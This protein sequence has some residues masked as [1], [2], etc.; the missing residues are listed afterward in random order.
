MPR[1]RMS[2]LLHSISSGT[3]VRI[4]PITRLCWHNNSVCHASYALY[5][6]SCE[7][8]HAH[9]RRATTLPHKAAALAE[10]RL[11]T[12]RRSASFSPQWRSSGF[13]RNNWNLLCLFSCAYNYFISYNIK[14]F[15]HSSY[16]TLWNLGKKKLRDNKIYY[17]ALVLSLK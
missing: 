2:Q 14:I 8:S 13:N 12:S 9:R 16:C 6:A 7:R 3:A 5:I 10:G 1:D 11:P 15:I 17:V 4:I